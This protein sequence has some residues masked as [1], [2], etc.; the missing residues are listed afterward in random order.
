MLTSKNEHLRE[1]GGGWML[2]VGGA[3]AWGCVHGVW[4]SHTEMGV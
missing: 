1:N 4:V 3:Q 2:P